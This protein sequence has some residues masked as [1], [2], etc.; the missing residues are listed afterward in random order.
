MVPNQRFF[1]TDYHFL[2]EILPR[3]ANNI[4][5]ETV[6]H[7]MKHS[8]ASLDLVHNVRTLTACQ[9]R[10]RWA[11]LNSLKRNEKHGR[12]NRLV[13][14]PLASDTNVLPCVRGA[15]SRPNVVVG[16]QRF[17]PP[18][19]EN[20]DETTHRTFDVPVPV[21]KPLLGTGKCFTAK[22]PGGTSPRTAEP[23][24]A[25][26]FFRASPND[27]A[28]SLLFSH[29]VFQEARKK[30]VVSVFLQLQTRIQTA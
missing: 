5:I 3:A 30:C 13:E 9:K 16:K 27:I 6:P 20:D 8:H 11:S 14:S 7:Q 23:D 21:P 24:T 17:Q 18:R 1:Q 25:A 19:L 29:Q 4:G 2:P 15:T 28:C 10:C 26:L 22:H 12:L